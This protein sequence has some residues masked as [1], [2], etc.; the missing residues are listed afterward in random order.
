MRKKES[1]N[2]TVQTLDAMCQSSLQRLS[3]H[4]ANLPTCYRKKSVA[5]L[6]RQPETVIIIIIITKFLY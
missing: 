2:L 6:V 3:Q 5:I 4:H 1:K